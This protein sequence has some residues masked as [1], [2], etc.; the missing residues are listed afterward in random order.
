MSARWISNSI[1]ISKPRLL[2]NL[3][4]TLE[5]ITRVV[6]SIGMLEYTFVVEHFYSLRHAGDDK[7]FAVFIEFEAKRN[8]LVVA[9][10]IT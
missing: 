8:L 10:Y 4:G 9:K 2:P 3:A 5:L 6:N 7:L 1:S